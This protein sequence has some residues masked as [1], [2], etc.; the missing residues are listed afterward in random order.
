MTPEP[1]HVS[2]DTRMPFQNFGREPAISQPLSAP[3]DIMDPW[4]LEA[5]PCG[6]PLSTSS[7]ISHP[8]SVPTPPFTGLSMYEALEPAFHHP[9]DTS[10]SY[11]ACTNDT[12]PL[13]QSNYADP[14]TWDSRSFV[15]PYQGVPNYGP[16][17]LQ[18]PP[19]FPTQAH[20]SAPGPHTAY[21]T[22]QQYS[23]V[24]P[25]NSADIKMSSP[26]SNEDD[27]EGQ[28]DWDSDDSDS[29]DGPPS[30]N[31]TNTATNSGRSKHFFKVQGWPRSTCNAPTRSETGKF[32]CQ[33]LVGPQHTPCRK[34]FGRPEHLS[35]HIRSVHRIGLKKL[36][37]CRV[38][39]CQRP[40]T[41]SDNLRQHYFIHLKVPKRKS[42]NPKLTWPEMK[43]ILNTKKDRSLRR[44]L[45]A[46]LREEEEARLK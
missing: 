25:V 11:P 5:P 4:A 44:W 20:V 29:D 6:S 39:N 16:R 23:I 38:P 35:R 1:G 30:D 24:H 34:R 42:N 17:T 10:V 22:S 27:S 36:D 15:L 32:E 26:V 45:K 43:E 31:W 37:V 40:F 9:R 18:L 3:M 33:H 13:W 12:D 21:H 19:S 46:K 41:R 8:E 2:F 7:S 28:T 14:A